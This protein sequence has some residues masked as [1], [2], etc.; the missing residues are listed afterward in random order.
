MTWEALDE[1]FTR[2]NVYHGTEQRV[3]ETRCLSSVDAPVRALRDH[4][5]SGEH[6]SKIDK[7]LSPNPAHNRNGARLCSP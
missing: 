7:R 4:S 5:R 2:A 3:S 6:R 1:L